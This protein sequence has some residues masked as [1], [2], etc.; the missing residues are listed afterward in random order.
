MRVLILWADDRSANLGVR[1]L[2]QG[3]ESIARQVWGDDIQ[4]DFQDL[5]PNA[6]G[7][8]ISMDRVKKDIG[9]RNGSIKT[10]LRKYDVI[11]DTGAGDSFTDIY[12]PQRIRRMLYTQI[13]AQ[14][15]KIPVV[16]GPQTVG[17]FSTRESRTIAKYA[18]RKMAVVATRDS[19][20]TAYAKELGRP[21][22]AHSTDV[23]FALPQPEVGKTRDVV[24][25]VSG[26]L[27]S[28]N[29]HVDST[30]YQAN[31]RRFINA[32]LEQ[33]RA[34][35]LLAHVLDNKSK[36]ND[37]IPMAELAKEFSDRIEVVVPNDLNEVR[38]VVASAKLVVGSR[39]HACLNALSVGTP[40]IPW[41][42]SRKFAPL[43]ADI[44]WPHNVD[45]RDTIDPV[46]ATLAMIEATTEE[47]L[48]QQV[49]RLRVETD[50][51]TEAFIEAL[52]AVA[53]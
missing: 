10:L 22:D 8:S 6:Q 7:Y 24:F 52:R 27:W 36:D 5:A 17:P 9:R 30:A 28:E 3:T 43:M 53:V 44:G 49:S 32:L 1:A 41:A 19:T 29:S 50:A 14:R 13:T 46:E 38:E 12:G 31:V 33:G 42:Y 39:M 23:V 4:V 20:S 2:A 51:R 25:N 18:L 15:L 16:M 35:T 21:S 37:T 48:A 47:N 45:L 26:L 11:L 40:S 34:V